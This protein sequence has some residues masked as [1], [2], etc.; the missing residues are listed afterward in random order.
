MPKFVTAT[1]VK[2]CMLLKILPSVAG[3]NSAKKKKNGECCRKEMLIK[4]NQEYCFHMLVISK[5]GNK[6]K[7][8]L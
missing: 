3:R 7:K 2:I 5:S 4:C 1:N 8:N 6:P